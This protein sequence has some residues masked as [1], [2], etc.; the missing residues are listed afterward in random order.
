MKIQ[1]IP[2]I[3]SFGKGHTKVNKIPD[4]KR[5]KR[6]Q[7]SPAL[8]DLERD[9]F[10]LKRLRYP[11]NKYLTADQ[12]ED[13]TAN[14]LTKA[15]IA[16]IQ[17]KGGQSE[18]INTT[19]RPIDRTQTFTDAIGRT[20]TIGRIEWIPGTGTNGSAD[21]SATI[22]GRSVKIEVKIGNDRQSA[23]QKEYQKA[24]QT[25]FGLYYIA[26]TF[27]DFVTWYNQRF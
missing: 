26:R 15:I 3:S 21:I 22:K 27:E 7:K 16:Y 24:V 13:K 4:Y 10:E 14:G 8:K 20:R 11:T 5:V 25:A 19:G 12:F 9:L 2:G 6:Y 18:R 1:S 17:L 23:K